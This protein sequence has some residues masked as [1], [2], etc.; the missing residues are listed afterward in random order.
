MARVRLRACWIA[1]DVLIDD[2]TVIENPDTAPVAMITSGNF[3]SGTSGW[4]FLGN[5][6]HAQIIADPA[7]PGNNVLHLRATGADRAHAQPCRD[8]PRHRPIGGERPHLSD[9]LPRPLAQRLE[10]PQHPPLFQ[11]RRQNHRTVPAP[12]RRAPPEPRTR[13]R[14]PN[15]GPGFTALHPLARRARA[16]RNRH[17]HR[18]GRAIPTDSARS[19]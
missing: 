16:R 15:L 1:G 10:P 3:E 14:V 13:P 18:P 6:R 11:P 8:H 4:R 19:P 9:H 5:H 2:I 12:T 17:R 7:N